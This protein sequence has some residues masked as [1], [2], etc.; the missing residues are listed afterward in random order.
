MLEHLDNCPVCKSS[1]IQSAFVCHDHTV[2]HQAFTIAV[3]SSCGFHFTNPRPAEQ[4][5]GTY[6]QSEDY[7]SHSD[8]SKGIINRLYHQIRKRNLAFKHNLAL[9]YAPQKGAL[10]DIGCGTGYFPEICQKNGW[11]V[12]GVEPDAGARKLATQK[13]NQAVF[14]DFLAM[15][16]APS[17]YQIV[18][19]WHVLEH[20]HQLD[21]TLQKIHQ[22]LAPNGTLIIAVPNCA[23]YDAQLY[24]KEWAAYD[25]PRHLYHF[26]PSTMKVLLKRMNFEAVNTVGMVF[27]AYYIAMLSEKYKNGK[28]N[29]WSAL[30][31][32]FQSN[33]KAEKDGNYSSVIYIAKKIN[34]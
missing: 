14:D 15:P 4:C 9:Q 16:A 8:T 34:S 7:I 33:A 6:Y 31:N 26:T 11:Q 17:S 23:S 19:M 22:I 12:T 29:W 21:A 13:L 27:D 2:S 5:I 32:G 25:V 10:L 28:I 24:G 20:I 1:A 3:C 18:T 30:K